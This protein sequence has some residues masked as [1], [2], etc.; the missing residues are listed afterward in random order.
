MTHLYTIDHSHHWLSTKLRPYETLLP[1]IDTSRPIIIPQEYLIHFDDFF[2][3]CNVPTIISKP[4]TIVKHL[5][6]APPNDEECSYYTV[7]SKQAFSYNEPLFIAAK[8]IAAFIVKTKSQNTTPEQY[9]LKQPTTTT[10]K[11]NN[12]FTSR[13]LRDFIYKLDPYKK[14]PPDSPLTRHTHTFAGFSSC[15]LLCLLL[16]LQTWSLWPFPCSSSS[17]DQHSGLKTKAVH[18]EQLLYHLATH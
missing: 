8:V 15:H 17:R 11:L 16:M 12:V 7:L 2:L 3:P 14:N 10:D 13:T 9:T 6:S 18:L 5:V 1:Y 4:L